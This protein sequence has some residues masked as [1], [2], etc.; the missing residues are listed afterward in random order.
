MVFILGHIVAV[1]GPSLAFGIFPG[2]A[3]LSFSLALFPGYFYPYYTLLALAGF[4]HGVNGFGIALQRFGV[5]LRLPN[6]GMM[7]ITAMA[8]TATV[9]ALLALG[10]AWFP[11]ADPMDNDYARLGMGVLSAIAD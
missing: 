2:F 8:L 9:L 7:T 10:G 11:I 5:N 3:G 1:R 6:R 4:Y